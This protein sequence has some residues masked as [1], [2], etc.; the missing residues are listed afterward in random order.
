MHEFNKNRFGSDW[1]FYDNKFTYKMNS[2]GY[3]MNKEL[4]DV[5]FDNY[6]AFFGCSFGV[7]VGLPLEETYA[8]IISKRL[9]MD[10][11]NGSVGGASPTFVF[12]NIVTML[13]TAPK[14]PK[15]MIVNWPTLHRNMY[16]FEDDI[17]FMGPNFSG[18]PNPG[19]KYWT[20]TYRQTILEESHIKNNFDVLYNTVNL[21]CKYAEIP[22]FQCSTNPGTDDF[23]E[24]YKKVNLLEPKMNINGS[25][26]EINLKLARDINL[27]TDTA[28]PGTYHQQD[29][30]N[31][32]FSEVTI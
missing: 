6:I 10:Y 11:I 16:W 25:I 31:R 17:I 28:H 30:V 8:Y 27:K 2:H 4:E 23:F 26:D 19:F 13:N 22:L 29:I 24:K 14:L 9:D 32:F 18:D 21:L 20:D 3:R 5:D 12:N 7:G 1:R 15:Y